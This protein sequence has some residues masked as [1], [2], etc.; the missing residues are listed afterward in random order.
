MVGVDPWVWVWVHHLLYLPLLLFLPLCTFEAPF[1]QCQ[2]M[3]PH[4]PPLQ[5]PL[6]SEGAHHTCEAEACRHLALHTP[7][8]PA[9]QEATTMDRSLLRLNPHLAE[10]R[11]GEAPLA[12]ADFNTA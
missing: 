9:D 7:S 6:V 3:D 2:G 8:S 10:A 11:G 5:A 12:A 4:H 1:H